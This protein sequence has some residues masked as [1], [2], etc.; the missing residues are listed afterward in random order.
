[1]RG[2]SPR[3]APSRVLG[4]VDWIHANR[5]GALTLMQWREFDAERLALIKRTVRAHTRR[6]HG[7]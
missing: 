1:M 7:G 4:S 3:P 5:E 2:L 6:A